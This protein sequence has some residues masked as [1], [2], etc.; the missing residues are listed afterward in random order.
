M[1]ILTEAERITQA[2][3]QRYYGHPHDNH[4]NTAEFWRSYIKRRF[5]LDVRLT[6]EDVCMMMILLK[7]SRQANRSHRDNLVD[8]AGYARNVEQIADREEELN[9]LC[10][11]S[12]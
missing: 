9:P 5:G 8:I 6:A 11:Y 2:D 12:Q 10:Q 3:R 7:V 1:S 4:G